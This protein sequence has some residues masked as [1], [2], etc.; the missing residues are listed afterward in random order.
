MNKP[1]WAI[2]STARIGESSFLPAL[3]LAG[4]A[5]R[6]VASRSLERAE[7]FAGRNGIEEAVEGYERVLDVPDVDAVYIP[8]PNSLHADWTI[9]ALRAGKAVLCEKPLCGSLEETRRVLDMAAISAKPLWEA[10]V[11]PFQDQLRRVRDVIGTGYIGEAREIVSEFHVGRRPPDDIRLSSE[12]NGGALNDLGCYPIRL[13]QLIFEAQPDS[14]IAMSTTGGAGVDVEM[15]GV[16]EYGNQRRLVF[17]CGFSRDSGAFTRIIGTEGE[18]RVTAPFSPRP[19][20]MVEIRSGETVTVERWGT[21]KPNFTEALRHIHAALEGREP[22]RRTAL[23]D[24][25]ATELALDILHRSAGS[26]R[27]EYRL[28]EPGTGL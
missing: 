19:D 24:S 13:A 23:Q 20:H 14:G 11:F 16:L 7:A 21:T 1:V 28:Q 22:P 12:L 15:Q 5:C 27:R 17:S 3:R 10:F 8:L 18:I 9:A 25:M 26:G 4:G 6:V 2:L